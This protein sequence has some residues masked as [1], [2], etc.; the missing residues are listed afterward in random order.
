MKKIFSCAVIFGFALVVSAN[1]ASTEK[2]DSLTGLPLYPAVSNRVDEGKPVKLPEVTICQSKMETNFYSVYDAKIDATLAW[3]VAHFQ[4]FKQVHGYSDGRSQNAFYNSDGTILVSVTGSV[5]KE[6]E[7]TA[8]VSIS[9][10]K[11]NP[12]LSQTT[13]LGMKDR[14]IVCP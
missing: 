6:G 11:F 8:T 10:K 14:K 4:G 9:Y 12:G 2:T 5:A 3:C 13:I 1:S 7:N